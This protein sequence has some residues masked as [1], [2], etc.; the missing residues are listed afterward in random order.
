MIMIEEAAPIG[1]NRGRKHGWRYTRV[2]RI[3]LNMRQRCNNPNSD[4]YSYYGGRGI[5]IC[6]EWDDAAVFCEWAMNNGYDTELTIDRIDVNGNYTPDNCRWLTRLEQGKNIRNNVWMEIN[7]ETLIM[8]DVARKYNV[9]ISSLWVRYKQGI[10][11]NDLIK[12]PVLNGIQIN[13]EF[14]TVRQ[15]SEEYGISHS[16]VRARWNNGIRDERITHKRV[17]RRTQG[18]LHDTITK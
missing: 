4:D 14:K 10:I 8:S 7:G 13:G 11:G 18:E 2:Y 17:T 3:W 9:P 5:S 6:K 16:T 1:E 12:R 15:I